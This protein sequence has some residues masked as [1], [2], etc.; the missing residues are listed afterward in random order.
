M[1]WKLD[2]SYWFSSNDLSVSNGLVSLSPSPHIASRDRITPLRRGGQGVRSSML[3]LDENHKMKSSRGLFNALR[4]NDVE[5]CQ[6][7]HER[8]FRLVIT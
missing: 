7:D 6:I 1:M 4:N 3:S 5:I 8:E 2:V